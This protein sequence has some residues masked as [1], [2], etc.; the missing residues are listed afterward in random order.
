M[1]KQ[2]LPEIKGSYK[3]D[4]PLAKTTWFQV[5]GNA[6]ILVKPSDINDL[7]HFIKNK[8]KNL[9]YFAL[10]VCSNMIIRDGGV[11]DAV[12]KLGRNFTNIE[13]IENDIIVAGAS[14]L[15]VNVAKFASNHEISGLEFLVG[16]PG[17][18]GGAIAMNAGAYGDEIKDILIK[19]EAVN[20]KG[21]IV[22]I[23]NSEFNFSY[24]KNNYNGKLIYTKVWLQGKKDDYSEISKK[25]EEISSSREST[26]PIR[27][28]TGGSTFKNPD[29]SNKK[30]WQL[31]DE[32]GCRGLK[33]GGA[34]VSEKHCNFLINT[35]D[36]TASD[37]EHLGEEVRKRVYENS[38]IKL[39]WEIK[40]IGRS[41]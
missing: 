16:I 40:R 25:M 33:I 39:E 28:R 13:L 36:A 31:I 23:N 6:D 5:G 18:I 20:S 12:I 17:T 32:A 7:C 29:N 37:L 19:A 27:S 34:Q 3:F 22:T 21:E 9:D 14:A 2:N 26:Q 41:K 38:S 30:A 8:P 15:D 11:A 4:Y 24:R 1:N 35:G 10:G